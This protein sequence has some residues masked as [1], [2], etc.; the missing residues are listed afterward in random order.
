M[1]FNCLFYMIT[2]GMIATGILIF[3]L[4]YCVSKC[5]K[6]ENERIEV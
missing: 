4:S 5:C 3:S 2:E 1:E 6:T